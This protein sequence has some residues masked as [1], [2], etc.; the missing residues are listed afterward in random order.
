MSLLYLCTYLI[1]VSVLLVVAWMVTICTLC[2]RI[3]QLAQTMDVMRTDIITLQDYIYNTEDYC[4]YF[5]RKAANST[6]AN[7]L[8]LHHSDQLGSYFECE[9]V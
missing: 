7:P 2:S 4:K 8:I 9:L 5:N 3:S 1:I 6:V